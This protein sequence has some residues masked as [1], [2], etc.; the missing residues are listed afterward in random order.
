MASVSP[1]V[2]SHVSEVLEVAP[3]ILKQ[4]RDRALIDKVTVL[5][6]DL[7]LSKMYTEC[8]DAPILDKA[9]TE[10]TSIVHSHPGS[11]L[12]TDQSACSRMK[13]A[14]VAMDLNKELRKIQAH[15]Q[16]VANKL[17]NS[18]LDLGASVR[19]NVELRE[20]EAY[21]RGIRFALGEE[22]PWQS[23]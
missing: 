12:E 19:L 8:D 13:S 3:R 11:E 9:L 6:G 4:N 1:P 22:P 23:K 18:E 21:L 20:L 17:A 16:G 15:I 5:Q 14:P 2:Y 7:E 10:L